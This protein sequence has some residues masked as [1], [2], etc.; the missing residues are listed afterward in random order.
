MNGDKQCVGFIQDIYKLLDKYQLVALFPS[1]IDCMG[2]MEYGKWIHKSPSDQCKVTVG[3]AV[4]N[5]GVDIDTM[6]LS[7]LLCK[8]K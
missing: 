4:S 5:N 8:L 2:Y 6:S 1:K 3:L 7:F